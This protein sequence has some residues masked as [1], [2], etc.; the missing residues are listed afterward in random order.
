ME[1]LRKDFFSSTKNVPI[2]AALLQMSSG[3]DYDNTGVLQTK[4][5]HTFQSI[6]KSVK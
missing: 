4:Q 5:R 2:R 1:L 3:Y 6:C